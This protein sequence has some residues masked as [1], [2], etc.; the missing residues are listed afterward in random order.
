MRDAGGNPLFSFGLFEDITERKVSEKVRNSIYKISQATNSALT[1]NELYISIHT[2]LSDLMTVEN[3]YIAL[4]DPK[5]DLIHFPFFKDQYEQSASVLPPGHGLTD[6]VLRMRKPLLVSQEVL[7][8]LLERGDV[9]LIGAKPIEWLGVP[10]VVN[11]QVI[12]VMATQSY[13]PDIHFSQNEVE[14]LEFVSNQ[15][16]QAIER[17]RAEE[18]LIKSDADLRAIFS[19]MTDVIMVLDNHGRYLRIMDTNTNLLY[20]PP[21]EL[22]G[23]TLHEVFEK[24]NADIFLQNITSVLSSHKKVNFEYPLFLGGEMLWF[25]ASLSP[26]TENSIIWVAHNITVRKQAEEAQRINEARYRNLFED[27]PVSLWEE[28][29]SEVKRYLDELKQKG[30]NDFKVYFE[31][32]P[33]EVTEC[34]SRIIIIDVN[35]AALRLVHAET[36]KQLIGNIH[37]IFKSEYSKRF[38]RRICKYRS[39]KEGI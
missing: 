4:Y 32:H 30:V 8:R 23:K 31:S 13:S 7:E 2:I 11:N 15:I 36:K 5:E 12:G 1:L 35:K 22:I 27:S 37:Q 6:Y 21:A 25:S 20:K 16:A 19:A 26:V 18:A 33:D 3:F 9:E 29:F 14:L 39:R 38:Y 24:E 10:L 28:D 34:I 17:K